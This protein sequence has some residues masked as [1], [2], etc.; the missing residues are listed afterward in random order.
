MRFRNP[1]NGYV[2]TSTAPGFFA[3]LFGPLYF[4]A[5]GAWGHAVF[6]ALLVLPTFGISW[7]IYAMVASD[8][9]RTMYLRRGWVEVKKG[10]A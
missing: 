3:L 2:E 9:L 5:K 8:I 7:I 10:E 1:A 6:A 4:G